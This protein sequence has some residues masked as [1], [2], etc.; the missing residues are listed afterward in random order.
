MPLTICEQCRGVRLLNVVAHH[1][2]IDY[3]CFDI[4]AIINLVEREEEM[5]RK[6]WIDCNKVGPGMFRDEKTVVLNRY[7][8]QEESFLVPA[9]K[10]KAKRLQVLV[11]ERNSVSWA[12]LP[13][14]Q[15]SL[16]PVKKKRVHDR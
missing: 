11:E 14:E 7:N 9:N 15:P 5:R 13:T 10:V 3:T 2:S 1:S 6:A 8:G 16:V 4:L 12:T